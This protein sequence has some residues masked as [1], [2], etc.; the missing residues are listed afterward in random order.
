[1][2]MYD[3]RSTISLTFS[4]RACL[5]TLILNHRDCGII[6]VKQ[7]ANLKYYIQNPSTYYMYLYAM[8]P[9]K[10][11]SLHRDPCHCCTE[12]VNIIFCLSPSQFNKFLILTSPS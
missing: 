11:H 1:M 7:N 6:Y 4:L 2:F 9:W 3:W 5:L 10:L 8:T 12:E